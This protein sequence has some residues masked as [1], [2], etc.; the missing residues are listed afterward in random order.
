MLRTKVGSFCLAIASAA[1][2]LTAT[3]LAGQTPAKKAAPAKLVWADE[4]NG[5]EGSG[6]D[7][8]KWTAIEDG[9]GFGN[10]ELEYY[11]PRAVNA[12]VEKGKLLLTARKETYT[13]KNGDKSYSSGRIESRGKFELQ[14]GR[15]EARLK[16]PKGQGI[17]PAF[18]MLGSD[19]ATT[20]WPAC[21]EIDIM[22]NIGAEPDKVHGSLHGPGYSGGNPLG[23]VYTLP[24]GARFS[25]DFHVFALEWEPKEIRF[26]VDGKLYETQ[27]AA[28]LPTGKRWV[29]DHPFFIVLNVAVGGFWPGAPDATTIFPQTM[30]VDYVRVYKLEA[31]K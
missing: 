29:F 9:S 4:F 30:A 18:W 27:K 1:V 12:H 22:E 6:P 20:G 16:L 5:T 28:D 13:G 21:G 19:Y 23:G 24:D 15:V 26:Y 10:N 7:T 8:A 14:Y 17:W 31:P 3:N 2:L 11:T 25:D